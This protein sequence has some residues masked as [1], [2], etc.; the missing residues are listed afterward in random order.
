MS[1]ELMIFL[2]ISSLLISFFFYLI[3]RILKLY[4]GEIN[5]QNKN[6]GN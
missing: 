6:K 4:D 2:I 1:N 3:N 5:G